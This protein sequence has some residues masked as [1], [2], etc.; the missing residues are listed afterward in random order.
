M[1]DVSKRD[2]K[3]QTDS[4]VD[5]GILPLLKECTTHIA[6]SIKLLLPIDEF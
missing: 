1:T 5:I 4:L 6:F 2:N 3:L